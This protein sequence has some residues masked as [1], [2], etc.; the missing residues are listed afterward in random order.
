ML[1]VLFGFAAHAQPSNDDKANAILLSSTL[2]WCSATA[3]YTN[4]F[5]TSDVPVT[6]CDPNGAPRSIWF[7]FY[8]VTSYINIQVHSGGGQGTIQYARIA[9]F[10]QNSNEI[11]CGTNSQKFG[12]YSL[13]STGL[14]K[15]K[16]HYIS[17]SDGNASGTF[18]LC[19]NNDSSNNFKSNADTLFTVDEWCST[20]AI[21]TNV[22]GSP[23]S[24]TPSCWS[25]LNR[26]VWFVFRAL[27]DTV[28]VKVETGGQ[29]GTLQRPRAVIWN[30]EG[31]QVGCAYSNTSTSGNATNTITIQADSLDV[32]SWY[33]IS[34]DDGISGG[35][36]SLCVNNIG[37]TF[38][39]RGNGDWKV[40]SN[41]S[42]ESHSGKAASRSPGKSD[43][44]FISGNKIKI[45]SGDSCKILRMSAS[46]SASELSLEN[47]SFTVIQMM[48]IENIGNDNTM[49]INLNKGGKLKI[50][51]DVDMMRA[52]G[53]KNFN[54]KLSD[55]SEL[56]V[57]GNFTLRGKGG[58]DSSN[59]IYLRDSAKMTV[60]EDFSLNYESGEA[61]LM[62][63]DNGASVEIFGNMNISTIDSDQMNV[64]IRRGGTLNIRPE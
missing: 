17:I 24:D 21:Y 4:K 41:W 51:G 50:M 63:I 6:S 49:G 15:S 1:F 62:E 27:F 12:T 26:N 64:I 8:S 31:I 5:A 40:A 9:L 34:V 44:V 43:V 23:D 47:D 55:S 56:V 61:I 48:I 33:W 60:Y 22:N 20:N 59:I 35:T 30:A 18:S 39:S 58:L 3:A 37:S 2:H 11:D 45:T 36:F 14:R 38:Y 13:A 52:G 19:V 42:K 28:V 54:I 25:G 46:N 32:G 10:D 53:N 7:K 16:W 29:K 57:M